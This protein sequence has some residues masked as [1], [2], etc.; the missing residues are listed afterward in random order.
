MVGAIRRGTN[1][2]RARRLA[3]SH[4]WVK[5]LAAPAVSTSCSLTIQ[6]TSVAVEAA[7]NDSLIGPT[8]SVAC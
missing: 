5:S 6:S 2:S 3:R 1:R 7:N 8:R 4:P